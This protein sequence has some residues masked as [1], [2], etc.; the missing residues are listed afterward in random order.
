MEE[1][2]KRVYAVDLLKVEIPVDLRY[3]EGSGVFAG[4]SVYSRPEAVS[5]FRALSDV[6]SLPYT[7]LSGGVS[8]PQFVEALQLANEA[9]GYAGILCG[10]ATWKGGIQ[11]YAREGRAALEDWLAVEG[12][13]NLH[14]LNVALAHASP[15]RPARGAHYR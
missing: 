8:T 10:R 3:V 14:A 4:T 11:V 9:G 13:G 5:S 6:T 7:F 15:W 1:F 2:S 12:V